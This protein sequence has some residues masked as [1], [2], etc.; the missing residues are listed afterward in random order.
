MDGLTAKVFRTYNASV[1]LQEQLRA[2]TRGEQAPHPHSGQGAWPLP[3]AGLPCW[4]LLSEP[5]G[6]AASLGHGLRLWAGCLA[7]WVAAVLGRRREVLV[8]GTP[9]IPAMCSLQGAPAAESYS[10]PRGQAWCC[11]SAPPQGSSL[12]AQEA[13]AVSGGS[14]P[15]A[16]SCLSTLTSGPLSAAPASASALRA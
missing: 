6:G 16:L 15:P 11:S 2:L 10:G 5:R 14:A 4:P 13:S 8:L 12:K 3:Q 7:A 9:G 1:T